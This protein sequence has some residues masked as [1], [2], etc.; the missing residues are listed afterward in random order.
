[1]GRESPV[2]PD[3]VVPAV[4]LLSHSIFLSRTDLPP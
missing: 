1:M 2:K 3:L 4:A